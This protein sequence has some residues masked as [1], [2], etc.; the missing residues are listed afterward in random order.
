MRV[1]S[2]AAQQVAPALGYTS[3][4]L[5]LGSQFCPHFKR[6]AQTAILKPYDPLLERA[7][8]QQNP[9]QFMVRDEHF[10]GRTSRIAL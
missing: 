8:G 6:G 4:L 9:Q 7:R 2:A 3:E 1:L 5:Q 10:S